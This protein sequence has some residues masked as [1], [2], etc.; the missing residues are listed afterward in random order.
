MSVGDHWRNQD[1]P[2]K[3]TVGVSGNL[4][5][6]QY[7]VTGM[8]ENDIAILTLSSDVEFNDGV[9]PVCQPVTGLDAYVGQT[10]TVSGWGTTRSGGKFTENLLIF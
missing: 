8:L 7:D 2:Y 6:P 10:S 5:H 9:Q 3:K 1:N 4:W